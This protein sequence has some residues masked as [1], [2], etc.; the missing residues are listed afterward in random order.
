MVEEILTNTE[1]EMTEAIENLEKRFLNIRAGRANPAMLDGV[2]VNYYGSDTPLK[3]LATISIPEARQLMIKPF[4]RSSINA[5]EKGIYEA[6][7][8]LTPN[9]NGE[10][11][12]LNI[13]ALT[14]DTRREYVKQ[15]KGYSEDCRIVLRNIRQDA[16]KAI[17]KLEI[18]EDDIKAGTEDVQDLINK[19]N[20]I[21]DEK[22]KEKE[23]ELM[24][25]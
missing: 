14:E 19:Y 4:D 23:T 1:L 17:E 3:Q 18:P 10:V 6:N 24:T 12:I 13:P 5:I 20:K 22:F 2:L 16:N 11:I 7:I 8:G 9:N 25:V 15:A 21:V